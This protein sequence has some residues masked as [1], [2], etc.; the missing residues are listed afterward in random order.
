MLQT[1]G[2]WGRPISK[3]THTDQLALCTWLVYMIAL[4]R[5]GQGSILSKLMRIVFPKPKLRTP[6]LG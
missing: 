6:F 4:V 5:F 3:S 2:V 1:N